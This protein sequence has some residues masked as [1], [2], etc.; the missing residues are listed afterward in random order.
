MPNTQKLDAYCRHGRNR[1]D[2]WFN[3][4]D[5]AM[6]HQILVTPDI[7]GAV[8][9]VGVHHGKSFISLALANNGK[10]AYAI[11]I[12]GKQDLNFDQSGRGDYDVF[13]GNLK[14]HGIDGAQVVIDSRL[15]TEVVP[16]DILNAVGQVRFFHV[17]GGHTFE[18][19]LN[20][21]KLAD[22]VLAQDG[23]IAVD[24]VFN[25]HWPEVAQ[26]LHIFLQNS[27]MCIFSVGPAKAYLCRPRMRRRFQRSL[28]DNP[29]LVFSCMKRYES[30]SQDILVFGYTALVN[31][32]FTKFLQSTIFTRYPDFSLMLV[33]WLAPKKLQNKARRYHAYFEGTAET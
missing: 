32:K 4:I 22:K 16:D 20:D 27:D 11:D 2:G 18:A 8:V 17:D 23:V 29:L 30:S 14:A 21:L 1:I 24:D 13:L 31:S 25:P 5:A 28:L 33:Q 10:N 26:A 3:R 12:F 7:S 9:E 19:C 15:S 6:F